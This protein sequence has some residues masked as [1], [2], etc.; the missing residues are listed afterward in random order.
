VLG[1]AEAVTVR[2]CASGCT[3]SVVEPLLV[4]G[5][6]PLQVTLSVSVT[7]R[8]SPVRFAAAV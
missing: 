5:P 1:L 8:S 4:S 3:V 7:S 2:V 6:D